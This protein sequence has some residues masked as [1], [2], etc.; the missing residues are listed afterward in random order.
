ML[1]IKLDQRI[2]KWALL[3]HPF[4]QAWESGK[5]PLEALAT[6]GREYGAFVN[7]LPSGW[8]VLLDEETANE[9]REHAALWSNFAK[10]LNTKVSQPTLPAVEKLVAEAR[11]FF[12]SPDTALGALYAFEAQQPDTAKSKLDGLRKHYQL[13]KAAE[14]YFELHSKN[15][16][17][18]AKLLA[19]ISELSETE[20]ENALNACDQMSQAMWDALTDIYNKHC[21]D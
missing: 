12:A 17:E 2:Q 18:A 4:Y 3:K 8:T 11:H 5:L 20:Q 16:H 1:K 10:T 21:Q 13:G 14:P 6:Y 9:E 15:Q 19:G 7:E